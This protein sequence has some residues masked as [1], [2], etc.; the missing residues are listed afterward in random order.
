VAMSRDLPS[1]REVANDLQHL[2]P[3]SSVP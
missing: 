1:V 2:L 3:S